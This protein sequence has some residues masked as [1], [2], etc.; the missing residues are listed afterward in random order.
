[1]TSQ[2]TSPDLLGHMTAR[3]HDSQVTLLARSHDS[4]VTLLV[5]HMTGK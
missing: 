4:Q 5:G 2:V 1:M 3:S